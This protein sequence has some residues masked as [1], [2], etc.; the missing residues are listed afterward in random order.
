MIAVVRI[1][2][3]FRYAVGSATAFLF[4][5]GFL[6]VGPRYAADI[7]TQW[8][9]PLWHHPLGMFVGGVLIVIG[10]GVFFY[11]IGFLSLRGSGTPFPAAPPSTLV[12]TGL[13][14]Y[15]RN[16]IYLAYA[17]I[18]VGEAMFIGSTSLFVYAIAFFFLIHIIV[19]VHEERVLRRRFGAD[20]ERYQRLVPRWLSIW[21]SRVSDA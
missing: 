12:A 16:P 18:L 21:G 1:P 20:Y 17:V 9:W 7:G 19:V 14:R 2:K 11:S 8:G 5:A 10:L 4:L 6:W 3:F 13:Y 15:S